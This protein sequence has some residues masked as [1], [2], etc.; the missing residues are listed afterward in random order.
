M[1]TSHIKCTV[2]SGR[3]S[4]W[5]WQQS[6][7]KCSPSSITPMSFSW[8]SACVLLS[9]TCTFPRITPLKTMQLLWVDC[10]Y[11]HNRTFTTGIFLLFIEEVL[12]NYLVCLPNLQKFFLVGRA[13]K[14]GLQILQIKRSVISFFIMNNIR[15][16]NCF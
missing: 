8:R 16:H 14:K 6:R 2:C 7:R 13:C 5:T 4:I 15:Q 12:V 1:N 9:P 11:I 10:C 3:S